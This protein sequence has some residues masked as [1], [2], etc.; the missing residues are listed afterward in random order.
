MAAS[1]LNAI[2]MPELVTTTAEAYERTAVDLATHPEHLAELR[3]RLAAN[4][5]ATPLFDTVSFT[6]DIENAY[7]M[8]HR[9]YQDGLGEGRYRCFESTDFFGRAFTFRYT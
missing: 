3:R 1:L 9:H 7:R 8:M 2:Q 4:R 6:R 5:R